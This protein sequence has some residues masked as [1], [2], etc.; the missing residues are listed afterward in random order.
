MSR[1]PIERATRQPSAS[2]VY[3]ST[4]LRIGS[5]APSRVRALIESYVA[6]DFCQL[7]MA[8]SNTPTRC[9]ECSS[10][11][12]AVEQPL[13]TGAVHVELVFTADAPRPRMAA[14]HGRAESAERED[15]ATSRRMALLP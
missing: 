3:S 15:F 6:H 1:A 10:T 9:S 2:R 5:G 13:P 11:P 12:R 4:T 7:R 8:S 14:T